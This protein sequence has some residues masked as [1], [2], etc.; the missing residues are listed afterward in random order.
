MPYR[1]ILLILVL[2]TASSCS[3]IRKYT[4]NEE[5]EVSSKSY[6]K[7]LRWH[8]WEKAAVAFASGPL[9]ENFALRIKAA[10]K[11]TITDYRLKARECNVEK[12]EAE[13][14]I[15]IDYYVTPSVTIKTVEDSQKWKYSEE[16]G[17]KLWRLTTLFPEFK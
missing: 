8:E 5:F 17:K 10:E 16:N 9:R 12:G 4:V 6:N 1:I 2:L 13:V 7:M 11:I 14:I 3:S 15:D